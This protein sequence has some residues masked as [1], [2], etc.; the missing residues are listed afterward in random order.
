MTPD[1]AAAKSFYDAVVGWSVD[2]KGTSMPNGSEYRMIGRSDGG[3]AGG[4]L[5][6]TPDM[7]SH[8]AFPGWFGYLHTPDVDAAAKA[9]TEAGGEVHMAPTDMEGVGRMAMVSDPQGAAF[10]LM[11][12]TPP[13]GQPDAV[14]DVFSP[15]DAQ[16][17]RWNELATSD[18]DAA[19][20]LYTGLFG[21]TQNG[22]MDMG[23]MGKY[24]FIQQNGTGIGAIMKTM[25]DAPQSAWS[26]YF[27][28]DDIDRAAE[29]IRAGGGTISHGPAE[30][31]GGEFSLNARDPQGANFGLVGPRK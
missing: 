29:A 3:H 30:I 15:T 5:T 8:G 6:L 28:V 20:S 7:Q 23:A 16:H 9:L 11:K 14:S 2:A 21:W 31:P 26:F 24:R 13:A 25:P 4:V 19:I 18:P 12:P 22:D 17:V 27:G 10:Y 1:P